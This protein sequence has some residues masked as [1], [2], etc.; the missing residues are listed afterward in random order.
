MNFL[1]GLALS[2]LNLLL[3]LS[4]SIFGIALTLNYT[5]LNPDFVVSELNRLDISSLAGELLSQQIPQEEPYIAEVIDDTIADLE[6]WIKEQVSAV[7]YSG[8]DYLMGRSQSLSLVIS[9]EPARDSLKENLRE[10]VLQSPPPELAG[11]SPDQVELYLAEAYRQIDQQLPQRFEFNEDSLSPEI[12]AGLEQAKQ[13]IGYFQLG[14]WAL[15]GFILLLILGIILINR[16]VR[17]TTRGLGITFL[18]Y[19]AL[20]YAGIFAIKYFAG[21]QLSQLGIPTS[22]QIWLPQFLDDFLV[23]LTIFSI[24]LLVAG[25]AL[26]V[27]S[28]VYKPRQPSV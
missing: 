20:E 2:L 23:P 21:T 22:L 15:I 10:A 8:Y 14:Y 25:V 13:S 9:L 19:G 27:V 3:F 17:S 5:F 6:P 26:I 16:Q 7:T 12:L 4:L 1:K 11:A 18:T 28:F 24:G